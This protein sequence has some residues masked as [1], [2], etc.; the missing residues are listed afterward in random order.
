VERIKA[1]LLRLMSAEGVATP[2][3]FRPA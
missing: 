2:H 1:D 3:A